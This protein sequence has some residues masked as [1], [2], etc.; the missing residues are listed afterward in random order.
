VST[1][2]GTLHAYEAEGAGSLPPTIVLHGLG[3]AA[4]PLSPL[5]ARLRPDVRRV[6]APE[7]PGHGLSPA[8]ETALT[9]E[10]LIASATAALD[11][12]VSEPSE[13]AVV[14]GNSLGGAVALHYA[15]AR[16]HRVRALVLVS[17]AG[18][19]ATDD[20][21]R[22]L[23]EAFDIGSRAEAVVFLRRLYHR[24]PWFAQLLAHELPASF[25]R[26]AVRDL[27]AAAANEA[28]PSPDALR[29]LEMPILL[30]WGQSERLLPATHLEYFTANLPEHAVIERPE[31]IGHCPHTDAPGELARLIAAFMTKAAL[32]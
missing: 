6:I 30:V 24:T 25:E 21:W 7:F 23:R 26:R 28:M 18:A 3:S 10:A 9:A 15:L 32:R 16:P 31:G 2:H 27:L 12:L 5:L 14:V 1:P 13:P 22:A 17:P 19:H 11:T 4:T 20:E 29:A 8:P